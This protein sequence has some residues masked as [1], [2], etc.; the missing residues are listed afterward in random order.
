MPHNL[1]FA[2]PFC[3]QDQNFGGM[4]IKFHRNMEGYFFPSKINADDKI[5]ANSLLIA[6]LKSLFPQALYFQPPLEA[7]LKDVFLSNFH[8]ISGFFCDPNE[9]IAVSCF[10]EDHLN[11]CLHTHLLEFKKIYDDIKTYSSKLETIFNFAK[12]PS[13]GFLTSLPENAGSGI[14]LEA[15][16]F[17]PHLKEKPPINPLFSFEP[18]SNCAQ[19]FSLKTKSSASVSMTEL[20]TCF[21]DQVKKI[22]SMSQEATQL[23][24]K[25]SKDL[26]LDEIAKSLAML[27]GSYRLSYQE[28]FENLLTLKMGFHLGLLSGFKTDVFL[29]LILNAQRAKLSGYF[30]KKDSE[31]DWLHERAVWMKDSL[32]DLTLVETT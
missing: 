22:I 27:K 7:E 1:S 21:I 20:L 3:S 15:Y 8:E 13:V 19:F 12:N 11:L 32:K 10:E 30:N 24:Y 14:S 16:L 5:K 2:V 26:I 18:F 28:T 17:C 4:K 31:D 25:N 23:Y 9:K 6:N 29:D